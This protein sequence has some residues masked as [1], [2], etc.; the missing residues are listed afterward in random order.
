M[1]WITEDIAVGNYLEAQDA[2]LLRDAGIMSVLSLDRTL[3]EGDAAHLG[4][5]EIQAV[6]LDD[7]PGNDPR[8]FRQ[9]VEA[10]ERLVRSQRPVLVQCHAGRS[11]SVVVIA[12]YLMRS[13]GIDATEALAHVASKRPVAVT[14]GLE[15]LLETL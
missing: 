14:A 8:L 12:G 7:G 10:V 9:A 4:L 3:T 15:Q 11:R 2:T 13:L 1:D 6:P 5:Q